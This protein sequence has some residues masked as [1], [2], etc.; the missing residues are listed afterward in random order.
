MRNERAWPQP[1]LEELCKRIQHCCTTL[2]RL[3]NKSE[4]IKEMLGVVGLKVWPVSNFEQQHVTTSNNIQQGVQTDVTCNV[5]QCCIRLHGPLERRE[6]YNGASK[7]KENEK[8]KE[9]RT[10]TG[11][12]LFREGRQHNETLWLL[13][14]SSNLHH[15]LLSLPDSVIPR[16]ASP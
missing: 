14:S 6:W 12:T 11:E 10:Q 8:E 4:Q 3:R 1:C 2:R 15:S 9:S 7:T 5:Q 13:G 16:W